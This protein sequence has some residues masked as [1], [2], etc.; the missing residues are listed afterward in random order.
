MIGLQRGRFGV[1]R[2]LRRLHRAIIGEGIG[3]G[4]VGLPG[5]YM[6]WNEMEWQGLELEQ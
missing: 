2:W 1:L 6:K 3:E 5:V 4:C